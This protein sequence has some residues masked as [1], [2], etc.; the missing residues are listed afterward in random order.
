MPMQVNQATEPLDIVKPFKGGGI[1]G[2]SRPI[3]RSRSAC[4]GCAR[5]ALHDRL[6]AETRIKYSVVVVTWECAGHLRTLVAT[7]NRFSRRRPGAGRR[8]QRVDRLSP[9]AAAARLQ[10]ACTRFIGLARERRVRRRLQRRRCSGRRTRSTVLLNPDT[11]LLDRRADRLPAAAAVELGCAGRPPGA[12][13]RSARSSRRRAAPRSARGPGSG[14]FVPAAGCSPRPFRARTEALTASSAGFEV[15]WLTG[16]C[17][18]GSDPHAVRLGPFDPALH[19]FGEDVDLGLRAAARRGEL[20]VRPVGRAGRPPRAGIVDSR[21]L[22]LARGLAPDRDA[23]LARRGAAGLTGPA[24][25]GSAGSPCG[26]TCA[27]A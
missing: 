19:M 12:Q 17:V 3:R 13:P 11:E 18:A 22:R 23:E 1:A 24:A 10:G 16:S 9:G 7:M 21:G 26:R 8:R 27:C 6:A 20:V 4:A 14:A 15:S 25:S 5:C 2:L